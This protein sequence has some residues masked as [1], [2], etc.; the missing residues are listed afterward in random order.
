M[1]FAV[2][3]T[4]VSVVV[5]GNALVVVK[6]KLLEGGDVPNE[7]LA[8]S[9]AVYEVDLVKPYMIIGEVVLVPEIPVFVV[10]V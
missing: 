4:R 5:V 1:L 10:A 9:V 8:V 7:L 3:L 2:K 6:A